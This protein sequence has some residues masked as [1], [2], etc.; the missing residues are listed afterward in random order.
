MQSAAWP[1]FRFLLPC[2]TQIGSATASLQDIRQS[3]VQRP[4]VIE[5]ESFNFQVRL[6][7]FGEHESVRLDPIK[8]RASAFPEIRWNFASNVAA[9]SVEIEFADPI[10]QHVRHVPAQI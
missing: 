8:L 4:G 10:L 2:F 3:A 7:R 1:F 9:E 6:V 5:L